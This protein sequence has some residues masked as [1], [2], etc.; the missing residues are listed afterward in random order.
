MKKNY[1]KN[2]LLISISFI[3]IILCFIFITNIFTYKYRSYK[4]L[5]A[6]LI[7]DNYLKI[8]IT[9]NDLKLLKSTQFIIIDNHRLKMELIDIQ[10]DILKQRKYY[11]EVTLKVNTPKKYHDGAYLKVTIYDHKKRLINIFKS[12]WKE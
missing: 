11:S 7:T 9:S 10:K 5:D 1:E 6:I 8:I 4:V 2:Q 3:F 12:C